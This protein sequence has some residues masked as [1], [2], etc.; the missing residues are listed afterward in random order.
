MLKLIIKHFRIPAILLALFSLITFA[1]PV[2]GATTADITVY[3]TPSN[4][5]ISCNQASYNFS[6]V[7]ESTNETTDTGYFGIDNTSNVQ[8]DQTIAVT[9]DTWAG[10]V[11]WTHSDTAAAGADTAG[12]LANAGGSWGTGDVIVKYASPD[13]IAENQ[14][15][16]TDYAFGLELVT[17]T[18]FGDAVQKSI[19]VQ[20]EAA[21]G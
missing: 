12:L 19:T 9:S 21:A 1:L 10:G 2:S 17:P 4:I 8:T 6:T 20:V 15:A 3:A 11:T 7:F 16:D 18:S 13:F 14:A 5:A